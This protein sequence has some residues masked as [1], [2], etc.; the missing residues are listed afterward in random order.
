MRI[1]SIVLPFLAV[2]LILQT[3]SAV[4]EEAQGEKALS[5]EEAKMQ[6]VQL[7]SEEK[8][9]PRSLST[10]YPELRKADKGSRAAG[11][12]L[13][14]AIQAHPQMKERFD[15]VRDSGVSIPE[16][17]KLWQP[18]FAE[19]EEIA[20]LE[21]LRRKYDQTRLDAL[22]AEIKALK[23]E[24][25]TELAKNLEGVLAKVEQPKEVK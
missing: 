17:M 11:K 22:A 7:Y 24:G 25:Y 6:M 5:I 13:R 16:M 23:A 3:Q 19:A 14:D 12:E 21:P 18:L 8:E 9:T 2:V 15:E 4:G 10:K 1:Q 20:D